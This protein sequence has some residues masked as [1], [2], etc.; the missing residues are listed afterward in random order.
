MVFLAGLLAVMTMWQAEAYGDL[1]KYGFIIVALMY[2][3]SLLTQSEETDDTPR[4]QFTF[5]S[6]I[7][8][9]S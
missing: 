6:P 3:A 1:I 2:N 7:K 5:H 9:L 4:I 8:H